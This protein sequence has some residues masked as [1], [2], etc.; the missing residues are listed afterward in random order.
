[1]HAGIII[2]GKSPRLKKSPSC[3]SQQAFA[4]IAE[5]LWS[6]QDR[7][8]SY[9]TG[10]KDM[11]QEHSSWRQRG[12]HSG[13]GVRSSAPTTSHHRTKILFVCHFPLLL[14]FFFSSSQRLNMKIEVQKCE[15][16]PSL[17]IFKTWPDTAMSNLLL[18]AL[19]WAGGAVQT[20]PEVPSSLN[21]SV[22]CLCCIS[23]PFCLKR[24][25]SQYVLLVPLKTSYHNKTYR[26]FPSSFHPW[27][28]YVG[29]GNPDSLLHFSMFN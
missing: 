2:Q 29:V 8:F 24:P 18:L 7:C 21:Y 23:N 12:P 1:M 17:E 3:S 9:K 26:I 25:T 28:A 13:K 27:C 6:L 10:Q 14:V 16:T 22:L 19:L 20:P 4:H 11:L 5:W 15:K